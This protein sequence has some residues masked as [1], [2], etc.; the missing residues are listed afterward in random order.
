MN[1]FQVEK[2]VSDT[3]WTLLP[4]FLQRTRW[5]QILLSQ[6]KT[7]KSLTDHNPSIRYTL[8]IVPEQY[9]AE[10]R[11]EKMM[12]NSKQSSKLKKK[13]ARKNKEVTQMLIL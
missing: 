3:G 4:V 12:H 5:K 10:T 2:I 8:P 9:I 6:H 11:R 7:C 1:L 13:I